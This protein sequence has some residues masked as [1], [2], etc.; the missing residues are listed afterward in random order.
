MKKLLLLLAF[1]FMAIMPMSASIREDTTLIRNFYTE[2]EKAWQYEILNNSETFER[3][4]KVLEKY[5]TDDFI[6]KIQE[7]E[8]LYDY[9]S[10]NFGLDDLSIQT[11]KIV[12]RKGGKYLVSFKVHYTSPTNKKLIPTIKVVVTMKN[13]KIIDITGLMTQT[14]ILNLGY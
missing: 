8:V 5:T 11:L 9:P 10:D 7:S 2:Y 1:A 3:T 14:E 6:T 13:G 12:P 4:E